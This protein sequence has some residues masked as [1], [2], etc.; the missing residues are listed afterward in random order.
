MV[1]LRQ[2]RTQVCPNCQ[3][4]HDIG[5]YVTGQKLKCQ[6]GIHFEVRRTDV[7]MIGR[8]APGITL[9]GRKAE[10]ASTPEPPANGAAVAAPAAE[11]A[12][13]PVAGPLNGLEPTALSPRVGTPHANVGGAAV[14]AEIA[15]TARV[16]FP[17]YEL[18]ELVGRGGMGEV[19]KAHQKS[20]GRTVAIKVLPP[21]LA[22]DPEFIARFEKEAT[23]LGALNHPHIVQIMDRGVAGEHY[24][25]VM[26]FVAGRSLREVMNARSL[27]VDQALRLVVQ[28]SEAIEYAHG[29]QIIHRDLKPENILLDE[30][31]A[32]KVA[33][34]G[35]AG[36]GGPDSKHDLTAT[37]VAM[38]T[39]NYMAPEQRRDAKHVDHR[40]DLYSLGVMLYELVTGELPIGRFKLPSQK[41]PGVDPRLD[42]V[43]ARTLETDPVARYQR[44]SEIG[45]DLATLL[46][47][48]PPI[49]T[50][51]A[52]TRPDRFPAHPA[53]ETRAAPPSVIEK[54]WKGVKVGLMVLG[55]LVVFAAVLR[56]IPEGAAVLSGGVAKPL[57]ADPEKRGPEPASGDSHGHTGPGTY[58]PNTEDELRASATWTEDPGG[59][60]TFIAN[61]QPG[62]E[63]LNAH[64]GAWLLKDG[65]LEATQAGSQTGDDDHLK[66]VPRA[67]LAHRY[68]AS[69]DL[70]AEVQMQVQPLEADYP[71]DPDAQR[72][73]ELAF[74]IKDVQVSAFAIPD[75][76]MRLGWRYFTPDGVEQAG[77]SARD[78]ENLVED[79]MPVPRGPFRVKL[80]LHRKKSS[81]DVEAFVNGQRFV[82]KTLFGLEGQT[83]KIALGCRNLHCEFDD[84][85]V[86]GRPMQR[87]AQRKVE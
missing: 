32:V 43:V 76:G 81:V 28:I 45:A 1:D 70:V 68:F 16:T 64:A 8:P 20:L 84:L 72:F 17:G 50:G 67:Y 40:A 35:L 73:S 48:S 36:I 60:A 63:E 87:P 53:A 29:K 14:K 62:D 7:S 54:G 19:W 9:A 58:P 6:C 27:T 65:R 11:A 56:A 86:V 4:P 37:S 47:S 59:Q 5:V 44:A 77:N 83:G 69:D 42:D 55:G 46:G 71:V 2:T 79:E 23:A 57:A 26:E 51:P 15:A 31:G 41:L 74:R 3:V 38:G 25:F 80:S 10:A 66:L 18:I 21:K 49:P 75:V 52:V 12:Q 85:K 33:D 22:K 24:F 61:F 39:V 34:F 13:V 30:S 82:H 78:L